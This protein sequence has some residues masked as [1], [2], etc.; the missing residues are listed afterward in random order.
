[1]VARALRALV[2]GR[3]VQEHDGAFGV[4]PGAAVDRE[5]E[6]AGVDLG[7]GV[8]DGLPADRDA[9]ARDQRRALAPG[10]EALRLQDLRE[11]HRDHPRSISP[12]RPSAP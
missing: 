4:G 6:P 5:D 7:I 1:V 8:V 3:L 10:A 2:A 9:A 12:S 11:S